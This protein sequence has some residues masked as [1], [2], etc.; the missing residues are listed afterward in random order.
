MISDVQVE[1]HD[2]HDVLQSYIT[3]VSKKCDG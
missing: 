2:Q 3:Y 1:E